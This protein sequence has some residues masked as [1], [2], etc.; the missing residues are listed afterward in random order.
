MIHVGLRGVHEKLSIFADQVL[1]EVLLVR[2]L[3]HVRVERDDR[4]GNSLLVLLADLAA[5]GR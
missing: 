1:E 2:V 3:L 5:G 4:D